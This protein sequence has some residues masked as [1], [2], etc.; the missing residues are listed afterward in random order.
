MEDW[1]AKC[2]QLAQTLQSYPIGQPLFDAYWRTLAFDDGDVG[3]PTP[4]ELGA[5][6]K[7]WLSTWTTV[8]ELRER[9]DRAEHLPGIRISKTWALSL[10]NTTLA[11]IYSK[12]LPTL[13]WACTKCPP[14]HN[15]REL[16]PPPISKPSDL[17][18]SLQDARDHE[19]ILAFPRA[20]PA[21]Q[22]RR[23]FGSGLQALQ[24]W[25]QILQ[26]IWQADG[27]GAVGCA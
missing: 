9:V 27:V 21:M 18:P 17:L 22:G 12:H 23:P 14:A 5:A 15:R 10:L 16:S 20:S 19:C 26:Y 4:P 8:N 6:Y 25:A 7:V 24:W 2:W 3:G 1:R 13:T 11:F